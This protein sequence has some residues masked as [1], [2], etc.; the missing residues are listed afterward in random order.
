VRSLLTLS[1]VLVL[2]ATPD[3]LAHLA[4]PRHGFQMRMHDFRVEPGEDRE[5]CEYRRLTNHEPMDV[6][7]FKL[8]MPGGHH[9]VIWS[10]GG[11]LGDAD[12]RRGPVD[13]VGCSG[14]YP[15][16]VFP[17]ILIPIQTPEA[18]LRFPP[19]IA[20]HLEARKQVFLNAHMKNFRRRE[21]RPDIR[22][23]FYRAKDGTV[24][25]YAEGLVVGNIT[26]IHIP[27]GGSQTLTAEW[28]TPANLNI[29]EFATHQHRLGTHA[30]IEVVA[31]DGLTREQVYENFD[32]EHPVPRWPPQP[33]RLAKG[34][35]IRINCTWRNPDDHEV[36]FG[37]KTT[38]EMC[39]IIGFYYRDAGDT[40]PIVAPGCTPAT[41]G[42]L[43]PVA[44]VVSE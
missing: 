12:F 2:A 35:K 27:A 3:A 11:S 33:I 23:N 20:L 40:E 32:W 10:Y 9:F 16:E 26:G 14:V 28:A 5:V 38:D 44:R 31:P 4:R 39:F 6:D 8:S 22:F 7:G 29:I 13:S 15:G 36:R 41:Q 24:Q 43:C 19:G 18:R 1:V 34:Q 30:T 42:L 37:P 21:V 17:Q 25:H